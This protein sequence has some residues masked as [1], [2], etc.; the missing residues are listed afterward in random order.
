[1]ENQY[2]LR[3]TF[4]SIGCSIAFIIVFTL[5]I[6]LLKEHEN[7]RPI[8]YT[9]Y[10]VIDKYTELGSHYNI[11][12]DKQAMSTLYIVVFKNNIT[13]EIITK[14]VSRDSYHNYQKNK[15]YKLK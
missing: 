4:I 3:D 15:T 6:G 7:E 12:T 1:M 11:F 10:T 9:E 14:E 13:G 2:T 8:V 5:S